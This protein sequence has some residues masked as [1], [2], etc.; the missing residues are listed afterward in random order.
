MGI[1]RLW[2]L[3]PVHFLCLKA[4]MPT[5]MLTNVAKD[6]GFLSPSL[7][8]SEQLHRFASDGPKL[9]LTVSSRQTS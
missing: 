1:N 6:T 5:G 9:I 2:P 8:E 4:A 3:A 7:R